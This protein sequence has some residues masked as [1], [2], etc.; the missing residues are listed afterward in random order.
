M[1]T[2]LQKYGIGFTATLGLLGLMIGIT[3]P[4]TGIVIAGGIWFGSALIASEIA[5]LK[6]S[7]NKE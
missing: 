5:K 7:T 1:T 4:D 6:K 3:G 2:L